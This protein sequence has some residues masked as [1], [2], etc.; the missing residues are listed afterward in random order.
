MEQWSPS[1]VVIRLLSLAYSLPMLLLIGGS[2]AAL[3]GFRTGAFVAIAGLVT[4][5]VAHMTLGIL[6]YRQVMSR[7]WPQVAPQE[8]DDEW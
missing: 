1:R 6:S 5:L 8:D 3:L 7:P 4:H 2:Y